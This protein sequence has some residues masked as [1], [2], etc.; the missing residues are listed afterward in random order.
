MRRTKK[1]QDDLLQSPMYGSKY[2]I[3]F[4]NV[5]FVLVEHRGNCL[6]A[7]LKLSHTYVSKSRESALLT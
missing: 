2:T 3:D 4:F 6:V 1:K 5:I 7:G